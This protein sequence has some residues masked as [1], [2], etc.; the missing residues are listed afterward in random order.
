MTE[1]LKYYN[2]NKHNLLKKFNDK[3]FIINKSDVVGAFRTEKEAFFGML[4][5]EETGIFLVQY[6]SAK[7][8]TLYHIY[9]IKK[10]YTH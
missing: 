8:N 3:F 2:E 6:C 4:T 1:E 9:Y 7:E 5:R 10:K